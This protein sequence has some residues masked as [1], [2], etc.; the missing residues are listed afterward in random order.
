[1]SNE[2]IIALLAMAGT[3]ITAALTFVVSWHQ[4]KSAATKAVAET[5]T[6]KEASRVESTVKIGQLSV[7]LV[8]SYEHALRDC[9]DSLNRAEQR[10]QECERQDA[11]RIYKIRL[12][13]IRILSLRLKHGE[14][15]DD[16]KVAC[17]GFEVL[18]EVLQSIAFDLEE[19]AGGTAPT[20][21]DVRAEIERRQQ[22]TKPRSVPTTDQN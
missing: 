14:F 8:E 18:Q 6:S 17:P 2:I 7:S 22:K 3:V 15:H 21:D 20:I 11:E 12:L 16:M 1:M 4:Q 13:A 19:I 5:E 9:E 10:V